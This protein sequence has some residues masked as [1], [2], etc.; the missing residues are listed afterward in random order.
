MHKTP[1]KILK[2]QEGGQ[3]AGRV[4][5]G[6]QRVPRPSQYGLSGDSV[7]QDLAGNSMWAFAAK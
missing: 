5:R 3:V 4:G 7:R 2:C 1:M 6:L